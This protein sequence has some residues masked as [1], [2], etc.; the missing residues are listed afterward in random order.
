[1]T[2]IMEKTVLLII[3]D[4]QTGVKKIHKTTAVVK[5]AFYILCTPVSVS[6]GTLKAVFTTVEA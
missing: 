6:E 2:S 5:T 3:S 4:T 1:M